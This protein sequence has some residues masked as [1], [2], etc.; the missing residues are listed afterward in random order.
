[1]FNHLIA[2]FPPSGP[3]P[4]DWPPSLMPWPPTDR[5]VTWALWLALSRSVCCGPVSP[6]CRLIHSGQEKMYDVVAETVAEDFPTWV[7]SVLGYAT[8]PVVVLPAM[9]LLL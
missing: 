1:M 3:Q 5:I 9:L 2:L 8:S 4:T 6:D 7:G